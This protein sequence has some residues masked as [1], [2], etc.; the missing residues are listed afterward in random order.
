MFKAV[1]VSPVRFTLHGGVRR[2][3]NA[4]FYRPLRFQ[5]RSGSPPESHSMFWMISSS[6]RIEEVPTPSPCG[7]N[8]FRNDARTPVGFSIHDRTL[9]APT[10][11]GTVTSRSAQS[12]PPAP[13]RRL[14][15]SAARY[16]RRMH[17]NSAVLDNPFSPPHYR[18]TRPPLGPSVF[19]IWRIAVGTIHRL[20]RPNGLA[21]RASFPTGLLSKMEP[22]ERIELS[23]L[24][25]QDSTLTTQMRLGHGASSG[26]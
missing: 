23:P 13:L 5:L 1:P 4:P 2:T 17:P 10:G 18:R 21:N 12:S 7:P 25:Y 16:A 26:C 22:Q 11:A 14:S 9:M 15:S 8:R 6:L 19:N 3:R 24:S 20:L